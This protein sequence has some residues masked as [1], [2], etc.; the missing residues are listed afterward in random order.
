MANKLTAEFV[1]RVAKE[2][3]A[4]VAFRIQADARR[5]VPVDTGRLRESIRVVFEDNGFKARI[6]SNVEYAA[7]VEFGTRPHTIKAKSKKALFW[8]GAA[9][10][11]KEVKHP[12]T[13]GKFFLLRAFQDNKEDL[14]KNIQN[15]L[16]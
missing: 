7:D 14:I 13:Q 11:V 6:G 9:H 3:L 12:G 15:R 10:P 16:K 1:E 4:K 2:E 8:K 5:N